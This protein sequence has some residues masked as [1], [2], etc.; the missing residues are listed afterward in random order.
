M[1]MLVFS[2][3]IGVIGTQQV[4]CRIGGLFV[5]AMP[6]S[7]NQQLGQ[8]AGLEVKNIHGYSI[9][10]LLSYSTGWFLVLQRGNVI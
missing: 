6:D 8:L 3:V 5:K 2:A 4:F 7:F 10:S 1:M 9:P